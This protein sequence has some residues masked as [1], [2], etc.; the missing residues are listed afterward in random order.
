[1]RSSWPWVRPTPW[2]SMSETRSRRPSPSTAR[3]R[4]LPPSRAEPWLRL[5]LSDIDPLATEWCNQ[6]LYALLWEPRRGVAVLFDGET[7]KRSEYEELVAE[8]MDF[9]IADSRFG[10]T[11]DGERLERETSRLCGG[12]QRG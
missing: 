5:S 7:Y 8:V 10:G 11:H 4:R 12:G 3:R 2:I 6:G 1:M 9:I